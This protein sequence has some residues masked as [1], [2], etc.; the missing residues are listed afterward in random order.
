MNSEISSQRKARRCGCGT[1]LAPAPARRDDETALLPP[2]RPNG[3]ALRRRVAP[4]KAP[5]LQRL[6]HQRHLREILRVKWA[7]YVSKRSCAK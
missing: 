6:F 3:A 2:P 5:N 1:G 7:D 4:V